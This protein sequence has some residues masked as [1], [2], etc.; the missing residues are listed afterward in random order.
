MNT[1]IKFL[2]IGAATACLAFGANGAS[3]A[4][5]SLAV[6][7]AGMDTFGSAV[8]RGF[9]A[10]A[11]ILGFKPIVID[12][13]WSAEK[14][15][16]GIDDLL[17]QNI[18]GIGLLPID[19]IASM[20]WVDK[21]V[22]AKVPVVAAGSPVG[23]PAKVGQIGVYEG[24]HAFINV[25]EIATAKVVGKLAASL[26]PTDGTAKIAIVQG[27]PGFAT[28]DWRKEGF[29]AALDEAGIDYK[30]VADQPTDWTVSKGESVC[31]NI[32]TA[33]P[34]VN[35]IFTT[36]DPMAVGCANAVSSMGASA[37]VVDTA[38][39]MKIGND[40]IAAGTIKAST[41]FK[42]ETM[43]R[44]I[45]RSLYEAVTNPEAPKG[46]FIGYEAQLVTADTLADCPA[47][48]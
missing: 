23:I 48:W 35:V 7:P 25:D 33:N 5:I 42:P 4:E 47:E 16:N 27:A 36:A 45:A 29:L 20:A 8:A 11:K 34:D 21:L 28:N 10:E 19:S 46:K 26:L 18:D 30:I 39:G 44:L 37:V 32:L 31:Q 14:M 6:M 2:R 43:G 22:A 40:A 13:Q 1:F 41:C 38:G 3:A 15:S 9:S 24:L 17:V 12:S